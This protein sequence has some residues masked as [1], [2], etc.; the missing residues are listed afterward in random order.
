MASNC[1]EKCNN[2]VFFFRYLLPVPEE[3]S[4]PIWHQNRATQIAMPAVTQEKTIIDEK[5]LE[6]QVS[7]PWDVFTIDWNSIESIYNYLIVKLDELSLSSI[8][9]EGTADRKARWV[10]SDKSF[11]WDSYFSFSCLGWNCYHLEKLCLLRGFFSPP[12]PD[13][14]SGTHRLCTTNK[15]QEKSLKAQLY[16][17]CFFTLL[18]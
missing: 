15:V 7:N 11:H 16:P 5:E 10:K 14:E 4:S 17:D 1:F 3:T 6:L 8:L 9:S 2:A 13:D 12:I 18:A